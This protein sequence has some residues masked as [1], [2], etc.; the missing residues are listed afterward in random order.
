[1]KIFIGADHKGFKLKEEL[2]KSLMDLGLDVRDIGN[3]SLDQNDDYPDFAKSVAESVIKTSG[4]GILI[5]GSGQGIC[6]AANK[7]KGIRAV[8][9]FNENQAKLSREHLNANVLCLSGEEISAEQSLAVIKM[10][11]ATPFSQEVRHLR[12]IKK[13]EEIE[14]NGK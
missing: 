14:N 7:I 3:T 8:N 6:I 13:I 5:C 4:W 12:R 2:K 10:W 1:M 11:M 9:I